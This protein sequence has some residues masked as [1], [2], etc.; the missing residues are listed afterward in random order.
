MTRHIWY[1]YTDHIHNM[2]GYHTYTSSNVKKA[3][4][5]AFH[6][7]S[8]KQCVNL[9][10]WTEHL[11]TRTDPYFSLKLPADLLDISIQW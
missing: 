11:I 5:L 9:P 8:N 2:V 7:R 4:L 3:F 1:I 6:K 10:D